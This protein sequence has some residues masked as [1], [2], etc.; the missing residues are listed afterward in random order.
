M[1]LLEHSDTFLTDIVNLNTTRITL[2]EDSIDA[3]KGVI[4]ASDWPPII[5]S[6]MPQGSWALKTIIK[7]VENSAFDA[8]LLVFVKPVGGWEPRDYLTTLRA[9]F[10]DHGTYTDMVRRF[11]H[12]V[13]IEYAGERKIDIAPCVVDRGG[14]TRLEVCNYVTNEFEISEPA[15]YTDWLVERNGWTGGNGLRKVTRL[16]KY[17]RDI[18]TTFTCAS[19][20]LTTLLGASISALDNYNTVDFSDLPTSL[21]TI[22]GR[23]DDWLQ[24]RPQRPTVSNPVL[25]FEVFSNL[26]DDAQYANVRDKINMYRT[27]IDDAYAEPD[28]DESIGKW[29]RVFGDDFAQSVVIEK[30]AHVSV[31]ALVEHT[32]FAKSAHAADLVTLFVRFGLRALPEGFDHL[33]HKQRPPWRAAPKPLFQVN[34][35]ATCHDSRS[36]CALKAVPSGDGPLPKHK[37]LRFQAR[38]SVG[39]PIQ[40]DFEIRWRV[41]N[42]DEAARKA[43]CLRGGFEQCNDESSRWESLEY[44][45]VHTVEAFIL[46]KR[47]K[48]LVAQ[49]RPFYV[50]IE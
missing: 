4:R 42:T 24:A 3:L 32:E 26:W 18:K 33:P 7:P 17:L 48:V 6:F 50:V 44:R 22:V 8:D 34:V 14:V 37:W 5:K 31:N 9:V 43:N 1:K 12:C 16:I 19:V 27:W 47:D 21:K 25:A 41:T 13:T 49:S 46:R 45:G 35:I 11:S 39:M 2:L 38:T 20:L 23:L 40:G 15:K 29:R 28:R 10:A 36:G 30:A